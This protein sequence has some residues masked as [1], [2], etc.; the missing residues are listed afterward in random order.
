MTLFWFQTRR[1]LQY[2][3]GQRVWVCIEWV[4]EEQELLYN[5]TC[6][7]VF[8]HSVPDMANLPVCNP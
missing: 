3:R 7:I 2:T 5:E 4:S 6:K 1:H 8:D